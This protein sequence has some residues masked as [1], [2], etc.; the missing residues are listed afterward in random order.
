MKSSSFYAT[1]N[2]GNVFPQKMGCFDEFE[3]KSVNSKMINR[4]LIMTYDLTY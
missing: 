2:V 3:F 1:W 4:C